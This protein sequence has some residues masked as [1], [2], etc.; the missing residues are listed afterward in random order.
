MRTT[1]IPAVLVLVLWLPKGSMAQE[2]TLS[3]SDSTVVV[4]SIHLTLRDGTEVVGTVE[5]EDEQSIRF[6]TATGILMEVP[7]DQIERMRR[8]EDALAK[9]ARR[10]GPG[11][12]RLFFAPTARSLGGGEGYIST[13]QVLIPSV[14]YGGG[15]GFEM[16]G[17]LSPAGILYFAPKITVHETAEHAIAIGGLV[18]ADAGG[19]GSAGILYGLATLGDARRSLT[20]GAGWGVVNRKVAPRPVAVVGGAVRLSPR[21]M[22]ISENYLVTLEFEDGLIASGGM[23]VLFNRL[24]A[25]LGILTTRNLYASSDFPFLPWLGF[26]YSFER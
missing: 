21:F 10:S 6:R 1:L 17:S 13:Y 2:D 18:G 22:L 23:R 5:V 26:S 7:L 3:V 19:T 25:D 24:S 15:G 8:V 9:D 12:T 16:S 4:E 11:G 20:V 14:T